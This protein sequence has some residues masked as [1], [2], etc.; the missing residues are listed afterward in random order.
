MDGKN[1]LKKV[2]LWL[3]SGELLGHFGELIEEL[4]ECGI[5]VYAL[6]AEEEYVGERTGTL[7][8]TD[9]P[10]RAAQLQ[11]KKQAVLGYLH[12][13]YERNAVEDTAVFPYICGDLSGVPYCMEQPEGIDAEYLERVYRRYQNIPWDILRTKR[14]LIRETTVADVDAFVN[15]YKEPEITRYTEGLYEDLEQERAYIKDYIAGMYRFYEYGVWTVVDRETGEVIGR[16]GFSEREGYDVP[17]LGFI[18]AKPWQQKGIATE[19]C[20]AILQ[21]GVE[22]LGFDCVQVLVRPENEVSLKLCRNLGFVPHSRVTVK[23]KIT[24]EE[25]EHLRMIRRA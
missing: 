21:Y 15:I 1:Y 8:L 6:L 19:I 13:V 14:C 16:A 23:D 24:G 12:T 17:E 3:S 20:S 4:E 18:I 2:V 9:S 25:Q 7:Y 10:L 11:A 5:D 22:Y